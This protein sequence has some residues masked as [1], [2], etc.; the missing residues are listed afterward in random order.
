MVKMLLIAAAAAAINLAAAQSDPAIESAALQFER[1]KPINPEGRTRRSG[2]IECMVHWMGWANWAA[3]AEE[4]LALYNPEISYAFATEQFNIYYGRVVAQDMGEAYLDAQLNEALAGFYA[5]LEGEMDLD[6][7]AREIGRCYVRSDVRQAPADGAADPRQVFASLTGTEP[8]PDL[9]FDR[10][11]NYSLFADAMSVGS[12]ALAADIAFAEIT[13]NGHATLPQAELEAAARAA[14][15]TGEAHLLSGPL[16]R[17]LA[18]ARPREF[19]ILM[20]LGGGQASAAQFGSMSATAT[21]GLHSSASA[22]SNDAR[23]RAT[24]MV[25][26]RC[27]RIGGRPTRTNG[28]GA[29]AQQVG[30][31]SWRATATATTVCAQR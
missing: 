26:D 30:D 8:N 22:A 6:D 16:R 7:F 27:E 23:R 25:N 14:L 3:F 29:P 5:R 9:L 28:G 20:N 24:V 4:N 13:Q 21:S 12:Y 15:V 11:G 10:S 17:S 18:E 31:N 1:S 19:R 2:R